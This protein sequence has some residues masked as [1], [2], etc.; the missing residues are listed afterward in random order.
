MTLPLKILSPLRDDYD[1][2]ILFL[3]ALELKV[4]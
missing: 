2:N 1:V 4:M 3:C